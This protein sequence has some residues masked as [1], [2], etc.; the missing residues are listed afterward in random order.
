MQALFDEVGGRVLQ[1]H[2]SKRKDRDA[3]TRIWTG[4][5]HVVLPTFEAIMRPNGAEGCVLSHKGVAS[6]LQ[7]PYLVLEDDA[8]P[9]LA[10][11]DTQHVFHVLQAI[12]SNS[13][14]ILYLGGLPAASRVMKTSFPGIL[15]GRCGA[16]YAMIVFPRAA[17]FLKSC[18]FEGVPVDVQLV[19]AKALRMAFVHPPLFVMAATQSDI[20]KNE[21]NKSR[22]FADLLARIT[23]AW[24]WIVVWQ[25]ELLGLALVLAL[26]WIRSR[27]QTK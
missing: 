25:R 22:A 23:P 2:S 3:M 17:E 9:T 13:F 15:E 1:I 6:Q 21:F 11:H 18:E 14:D 26:V 4:A 20:G 5:H 19:R 7:A 16:T 10:M 12:Q 8:L 27:T 24:R